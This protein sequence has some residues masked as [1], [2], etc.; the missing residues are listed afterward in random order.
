MAFPAGILKQPTSTLKEWILTTDDYVYWREAITIRVWPFLDFKNRK[1]LWLTYRDPVDKQ[2]Q[3]YLSENNLYIGP[4]TFSSEFMSVLQVACRLSDVR[5]VDYI[6]KHH[7]HQFD[8]NQL[9]VNTYSPEYDAG[10]TRSYLVYHRGTGSL[11]HAAVGAKSMDILKILVDCGASLETTDCCRETPLLTAIGALENELEEDK[12]HTTPLLLNERD[13]KYYDIILYLIKLGANV[14]CQDKNGSTALMF[15]KQAISLVPVLIKAG[16]DL[17]LTNDSGHTVIH[18]AVMH[19]NVKLLSELLSCQTSV[20]STNTLVPHP[21]FFNHHMLLDKYSCSQLDE[22]HQ[23]STLFENQTG[24]SSQLIVDNL[25]LIVTYKY[26]YFIKMDTWKPD[27][28][29]LLFESFHE[30]IAK[31][32]QLHL[33][34]PSSEP[35]DAYGGLVEIQSLEHLNHYT[36]LQSVDVRIKLGYQCL[37]IRER[38]LGY[39]DTTLITFLFVFGRWMLTKSHDEGWLLLLRGSKMLLSQ[40]EGGNAS[41]LQWF[42]YLLLHETHLLFTNYN[43]QPETFSLLANI[44]KCLGLCNDLYK[45]KHHHNELSDYETCITCILSDLC[46]LS[47]LQ[48]STNVDE[49]GK[50]MIAKCQFF[51]GESINDPSNILNT[52]VAF[53][54]DIDFIRRVLHWG[55]DSLV[56]ECG[57]GYST[58]SLCVDKPED[59]KELLLQHGA[60]LDAVDKYGSSSF[61]SDSLQCLC[62]HTIITTGI[63]YDTLDLPRHIKLL[64]SFHDP[65]YIRNKFEERIDSLIS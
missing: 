63:P 60:H 25:L 33:P 55:G 39:G 38:C 9:M 35:H 62:A 8:I 58:I 10:E 13:S 15:L 61:P 64:I 22:I 20:S 37:I 26:Y 1:H 47:K 16:A 6:L 54:D 19:Q 43:I 3:N 36:N 14:N 46:K 41:I 29:N 56:N 59:I 48:Y 30:A 44:I 51:I 42:I 34:F 32:S 31:R 2:L 12:R 23:I 24:F 65:Q 27:D 45:K 18:N 4:N 50:L 11:M 40:L 57:S 7:V 17:L 52:A 21:L 49:L 53:I 28:I 5:F